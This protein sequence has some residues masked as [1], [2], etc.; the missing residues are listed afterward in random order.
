MRAVTEH[1]DS[2][3]VLQSWLSDASSVFS[4]AVSH[5]TY[6]QLT[7]GHTE[8]AIFGSLNLAD[9]DLVASPQQYGAKAVDKTGVIGFIA[10][11]IEQAIDFFHDIIPERNIWI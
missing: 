5:G 3:A 10:T 8:H 4:H 11:Y 7:D 2:V 1:I 6:A 9:A